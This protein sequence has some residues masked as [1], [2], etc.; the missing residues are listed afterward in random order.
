MGHHFTAPQ[1][2]GRHRFLVYTFNISEKKTPLI[3]IVY[4]IHLLQEH[5]YIVSLYTDTMEVHYIL[6]SHTFLPIYYKHMLQYSVMCF[7]TILYQ[8]IKNQ[9]GIFTFPNQCLDV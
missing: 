9:L 7:V 5:Q 4:C 1:M 6:F 3:N 8:I 2:S